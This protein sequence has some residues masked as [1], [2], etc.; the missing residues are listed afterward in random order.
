MTLLREHGVVLV[1]H[2]YLVQRAMLWLR[3]S[4]GCQVVSTKANVVSAELPDAIGWKASG[5]STL[6]ECK[7]SRSDFWR[8]HLKAHRLGRGGGNE[9]YYLTPPGLIGP[10]E[11]PEGWGLLE[12]HSRAIRVLRNA[13]HGEKDCLGEVRLLLAYIRRGGE[14]FVPD[15][16]ADALPDVGL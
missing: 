9:R 5:W 15:L 3:N 10:S 12:C 16:D 1:T 2:A 4:H 7:M 11:I 8:D 14:D 6:V 13:V